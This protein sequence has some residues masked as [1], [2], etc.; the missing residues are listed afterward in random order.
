MSVD[1]NLAVHITGKAAVSALIGDRCYPMGEAPRN[2]TK[3]YITLRRL[4]NERNPH[5]T[6]ASGLEAP[7]YRATVYAASAPAA[8]TVRDTLAGAIHMDSGQIGE[9]G[10]ETNVRRIFVDDDA[11]GYEGPT[12]GK[13]D[14]TAAPTLD[15]TVWIKKEV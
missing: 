1:R 4:A 5:M 2:A 7:L 6:G 12:H 8:R 9:E 3:P 13:E 10:N 15:F 14:G 11:D